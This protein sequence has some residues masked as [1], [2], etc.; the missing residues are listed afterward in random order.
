M[1]DFSLAVVKQIY[2]QQQGIFGLAI[3]ISGQYALYAC[4][5]GHPSVNQSLQYSWKTVMTLYPKVHFC[6]NSAPCKLGKL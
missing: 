4:K 3:G 5:E 2:V 1:H 6:D